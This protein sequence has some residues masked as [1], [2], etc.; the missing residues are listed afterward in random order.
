MLAR[1][2]AGDHQQSLEVVRYASAALASIT[3]E[4]SAK[5]CNLL[6]YNTY[7]NYSSLHFTSVTC[8]YIALTMIGAVPWHVRVCSCCV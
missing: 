2:C 1:L 5:V 8:A 7:A 3:V 4:A 6:M